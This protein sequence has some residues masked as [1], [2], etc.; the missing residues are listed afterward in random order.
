MANCITLTMSKADVD[1]TD[2]ELMMEN[3]FQALYTVEMVLKILGQGF[4]FNK[5]AYLKDYFNIL[6]FFIVMSA[7]LSMLQSEGD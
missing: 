7:Y 3:I 5:G 4:I 2:T 6:D 1:P